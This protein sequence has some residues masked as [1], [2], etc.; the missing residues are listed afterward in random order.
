MPN[1]VGLVVSYFYIFLFIG[2]ATAAMKFGKISTGLSRKIIHIGVSHWWLIA[3][4]FFTS[5]FWAMIGPIT[6]II[7]NALSY[8][9]NIFEAMDAGG[10]KSNLGTVYFPI[11]LLVLVLLAWNG[12][13]PLYA[14]ALGVLIMGW[15]DGLAAIVG[16]RGLKSPKI[17]LFGINKSLS[18]TLTMFAVSIIVAVVILSVFNPALAV[19]SI[20]LQAGVL[21]LFATLIELFTPF[22]IDNLTV[23]ILTAVFYQAV[24]V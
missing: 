22:G 19:T 18:G 7:L 20:L 15:G 11:S 5:P 2:I 4:Y 1:I 17:N 14:G 16:S 13:I 12:N 8:K 24:F 10:K 9:I 3:M 21:S 23:P 6:F